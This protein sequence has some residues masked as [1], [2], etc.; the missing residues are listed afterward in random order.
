MLLCPCLIRETADKWKAQ[1]TIPAQTHDFSIFTNYVMGFFILE[2]RQTL[3]KELSVN[4]PNS[5]KE[6]ACILI[7]VLI[8]MYLMQITLYQRLEL[9]LV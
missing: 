8:A 5:V 2:S 3:G 4:D 7:Q 6:S 9:F 1:E